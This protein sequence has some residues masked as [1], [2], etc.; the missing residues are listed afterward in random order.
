MLNSLH[1]AVR[2]QYVDDAK[3]VHRVERFVL[4]V[5]RTKPALVLEEKEMLPVARVLLR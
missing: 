5:R 2:R 3:V 1:D 4:F